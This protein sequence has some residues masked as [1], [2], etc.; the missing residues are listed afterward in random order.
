MRRGALFA[1]T[2]LLLALLL[3]CLFLQVWV[4]PHQIERATTTFPETAPLALPGLLWGVTAIAC[5]ETIL[6]IGLRLVVLARTDK[7][8]D[9]A[10]GWLRA[11][12]GCLLAFIVLVV[13]AITALAV[14]GY[15]SPATPELVVVG[16]LALIAAVALVAFPATRRPRTRSVR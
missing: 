3:A 7:F 12:V 14:K 6:I 8:E 9:D 4:L 1:L 2:A 16:G 10:S 5:G 11:I 15:R 13:L